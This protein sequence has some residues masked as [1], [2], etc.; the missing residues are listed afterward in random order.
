MRIALL[1]DDIDQAALVKRWLTADGHS[2]VH[3]RDAEQLLRASRHQSFDLYMLDWVLPAGSGLGVLKQLRARDQDGPPVL[4]V[5]MRSD[6]ACIVEAL[7]AGAD[8]Y[9]VKP[10]RRAETLA[11]V[12]ALSRRRLGAQKEVL[13]EEPYAFDL[14]QHRLLLN[15]TPLPLTEREFELALFF[16]RRIGQIVSRQHL[17]ESVWGLGHSA[18]KTRTV[19]THVSRLRQ[20]L[21]L[22]EGNGFKLTSIYQH[23][24]RLENQR[25]TDV[26]AETPREPH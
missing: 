6:E 14:E 17:L 18:M 21:K 1:E 13:E 22:G 12:G 9:M 25:G 16:F 8:D 7:Q 26:A 19:D 3:Y 5:T 11:R 10:V 23:G 2:I 20:K 4:F 24:Y 15:G